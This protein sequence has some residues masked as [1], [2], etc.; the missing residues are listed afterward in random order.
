MT[1]GAG[2]FD[3]LRRTEFALLGESVYLDAASLAPLPER[4]RHALEAYNAR[5]GAVQT[6]VEE[7]FTRPSA[8]AR[9][10]IAGLIG[11]SPTE[12]ALG[13]NT[14]FGINLAAVGLKVPY[15]SVVLVSAGEFPANVY[16]W[17]GQDHL[18]LEIVPLTAQ[19]W[20]DEERL[21]DAL[22]RPEVSIL[23]LSS[24]QFSTGY[25]ADLERIGTACREHDVFFVVDAIQ[26]LG[27]CPID[28]SRIPADVIASGSHKWLCS[29]FGA[30][31][32][33]VRR[34]VQARL[35]PRFIGWS[36]M[37][38]S[39]DL[40]SVVDY[41]WSPVADA[42]RY[43][44]GT[45]P[46]QDQLGLSHSIDLLQEVGVSEIH[47]HVDALLEPLRTWLGDH[48]E[49]RVLSDL[50]PERRAGILSF[51]PPDTSRAFEGLREAGI[52]CSLREGGIRIAPHLYNTHADIDRL[53][54]VLD[55]LAS[56]GWR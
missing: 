18:Q 1:V 24:V 31:F 13:G 29:P 42:R 30:G 43:E 10:R 15:R 32:C 16:P 19:G 38:S 51:A 41:S 6:M 7:D 12:I 25:R 36:G 56:R 21:I 20:P 2:R 28:V 39:G 45:Q 11:A 5:R 22:A 37:E 8:M 9:D 52:R 50:A 4:T 49:V 48:L 14:S 44:V 33:Y 53:L 40:G 47:G 34:E 3:E 26:S 17:M 27:I 35:T 46:L 55:S 54:D 23:A